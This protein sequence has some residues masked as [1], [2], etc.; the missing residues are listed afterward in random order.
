M[1]ESK[2]SCFLCDLGVPTHYETYVGL[3]TPD[4]EK[5]AVRV[6]A[7]SKAELRAKVA[8]LLGQDD[9]EGKDAR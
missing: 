3:T 2:R 5:V 1:S 4:G 7:A 8:R 9:S 6:R